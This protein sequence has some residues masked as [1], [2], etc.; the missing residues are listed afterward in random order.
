MHSSC[1]KTLSRSTNIRALRRTAMCTVLTHV[2]DDLDNLQRGGGVCHGAG[3]H[4][5]VGNAL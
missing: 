1:C 2:E 3:G 4:R 5:A